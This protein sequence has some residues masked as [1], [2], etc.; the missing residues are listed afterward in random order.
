[1]GAGLAVGLDSGGRLASRLDFNLV[2]TRKS[3]TDHAYPS[4]A[5][6]GEKYALTPPTDRNLMATPKTTTLFLMDLSPAGR[7][8]CP[9]SR[10]S[11]IRT[12]ARRLQVLPAPAH[13]PRRTARR[14]QFH[15][16]G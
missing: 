5:R 12:V 11:Q 2:Q 3:S 1:M 14:A 15:L 10:S 9:Q 13:M 6:S 16:H 4:T 7:I 8:K